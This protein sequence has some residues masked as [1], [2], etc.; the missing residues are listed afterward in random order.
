MMT[1]TEEKWF[2]TA[3]DKIQKLA[4]EL[5][6]E[7]YDSDVI[8]MAMLHTAV[9]YACQNFGT[10]VAAEWVSRNANIALEAHRK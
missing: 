10:S 3:S 2:L 9:F 8:A 7:D 6:D 4:M 5:D 1:K